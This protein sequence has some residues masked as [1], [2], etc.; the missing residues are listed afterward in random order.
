M[1]LDHVHRLVRRARARLEAVRLLKGAARGGL[2]GCAAGLLAVAA[3]KATPAWPVFAALPWILFGL[4]A[5]I[6]LP[7][8]RLFT[9]APPR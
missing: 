1:T 6:A 3:M 8:M 2:A 7:A 9:I 4:G 5:M